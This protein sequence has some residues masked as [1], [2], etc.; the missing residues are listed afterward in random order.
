VKTRGAC[1]GDVSNEVGK[2]VNGPSGG[3]DIILSERGGREGEEERGV[4]KTPRG[5]ELRA[6]VILKGF[7]KPD[8]KRC[9]IYAVG[10]KNV[11]KCLRERYEGGGGGKGA[12]EP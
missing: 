11:I 8:K 4:K 12:S 5:M 2:K 3:V 7:E 6:Q 9:G 1:V 10:I